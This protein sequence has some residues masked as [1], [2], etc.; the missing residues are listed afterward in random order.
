M[1]IAELL[2]T[3]RKSTVSICLAGSTKQIGVTSWSLLWMTGSEQMSQMWMAYI[4]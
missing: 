4:I 3:L 2:A 1:A